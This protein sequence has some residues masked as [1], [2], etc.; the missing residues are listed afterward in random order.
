MN[1]ATFCTTWAEPEVHRLLDEAL[2]L[3]RTRFSELGLSAPRAE[4]VA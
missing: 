3:L 1:L 4:R 2:S